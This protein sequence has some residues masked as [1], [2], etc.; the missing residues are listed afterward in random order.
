MKSVLT[1]FGAVLFALL[2][3]QMTEACMGSKQLTQLDIAFA[4]V[5]FEGSLAD[6]NEVSAKDAASGRHYFEF[7]FD[8]D[9]VVRGKLHQDK[10]VIGWMRGG[11]RNPTDLDV[12]YFKK[13]IGE[14]T[15]VAI[16]T[17]KLASKF[18]EFKPT[19]YDF[20]DEDK[21]AHV[22]AEQVELVC[23]YTVDS[24]KPALENKIPFV[25]SNGYTCNFSY[26]FPVEEYEDMLNYGK[27]E[28]VYTEALKKA[29]KKMRASKDGREAYIEL[30]KRYKEMVP[31]GPLMWKVPH[32]NASNTAIDLLRRY[33]L[34]FT[35]ALK[36]DLALQNSALDLGVAIA[37]YKNKPRTAYFDRDEA[38]LE[39]FREDLRREMMRLLDYIEKDPNF[40]NR[41]L[42]ED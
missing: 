1:V 23:D 42:M 9:D 30:R 14:T 13:Y 18:C 7:T 28:K 36:N 3:P 20:Y 37:H 25:L 12:D 15:R 4:D 41:L 2:T 24:L 19:S 39:K 26:L 29:R 35:P 21:G 10:V 6:I 22:D 8:V 38:S 11:H 27:N 33:K 5:I 32:I 31:A 17:P 34:L 40:M 16:S